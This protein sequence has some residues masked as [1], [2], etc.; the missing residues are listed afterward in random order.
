MEGP[1]PGGT[2]LLITVSPAPGKYESVNESA[3]KHINADTSNIKLNKLKFY[4]HFIIDSNN[5]HLKRT[6]ITLLKI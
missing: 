6:L 2:A 3:G 4:A 5:L 1:H